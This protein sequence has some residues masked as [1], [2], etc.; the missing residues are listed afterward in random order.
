MEETTY[1]D[2]VMREI[3][4]VVV[5]GV[6]GNLRIYRHPYLSVSSRSG[7]EKKKRGEAP[8]S[9]ALWRG[10]PLGLVHLTLREFFL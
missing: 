8:G 3:C 5:A 4:G 10:G 2:E 6:P 9:A 7:K 1:R